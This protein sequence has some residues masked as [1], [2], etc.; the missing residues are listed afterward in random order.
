[1][2]AS[3]GW[4][5]GM[6]LGRPTELLIAA[7]HRIGSGERDAPV[8]TRTGDPH[9]DRL[10]AA[11]AEMQRDIAEHRAA[12]ERAVLRAANAEKLAA[13]GTL[14]AG[15]AHQVNNPLAG[16]Q[17]C[18]EMAASTADA[19]ERREYLSLAEEGVAKLADVMG[20]LV[21]YVRGGGGGQAEV[22]VNDVVRSAVAFCVTWDR[23]SD[24][25]PVLALAEDLPPVRGEADALSDVVVNLYSNARLAAPGRPIHVAT[26]QRGGGVVVEVTDDGPGVP[27]ELR[28]R[29]FDPFFTTR[30]QGQGTGLGLALCEAI[31]HRHGGSIEVTDAP[32]GGA[33][34]V[35]WLRE[36]EER[37]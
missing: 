12:E 8:P 9:M 31:V 6:R 25:P 3:L 15:I 16:I 11:F 35:V 32:S 33:R 37:A 29:I 20:R 18:L 30:P 23:S 28:Q 2:A 21:A 22:Q 10:A 5:F 14:V 27:V 13:L 26:S 19:A 24:P 4:R 36:M 1:V 17:S 7:A 34:F